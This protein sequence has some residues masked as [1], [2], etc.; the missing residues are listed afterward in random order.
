M[1]YLLLFRVKKE[2]LPCCIQ[3]LNVFSIMIKC[4]L[5]TMFSWMEYAMLINFNSM[6]KVNQWRFRSSPEKEFRALW[7]ANNGLSCRLL[8]NYNRLCQLWRS[9]NPQSLTNKDRL[10]F[11][12]ILLNKRPWKTS[13][14][15]MI[16]KACW[17]FVK[18]HKLALSLN[19]LCNLALQN[20]TTLNSD[21][22][23]PTEPIDVKLPL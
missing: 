2:K 7:I 15:L 4:M 23:L 14:F 1:L 17:F 3:F 22:Q 8:F 9:L 5:K 10:N 12:Q 19:W 18:S 21:C 20:V 13:S 6:N 16:S 11:F